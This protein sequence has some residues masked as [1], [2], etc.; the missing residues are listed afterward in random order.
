MTANKPRRTKPPDREERVARKRFDAVMGLTLK[1]AKVRE[2]AMGMPAGEG[3]QEKLR[4]YVELL[5]AVAGR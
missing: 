3:R 2:E 1:A 5:K 4:E